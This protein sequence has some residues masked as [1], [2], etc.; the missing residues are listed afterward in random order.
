MSKTHFPIRACCALGAALLVFPAA[1]AAD[2]PA[3]SAPAANSAAA[4]PSPVFDALKGMKFVTNARPAASA[5]YYIILESASWCGPCRREMPLIVKAYPEMKAAGVELVQLSRD[6]DL[7]AAE[8]WAKDEN[9]PF[10]IV[11]PGSEPKFPKALPP[12]PGIPQMYILNAAGDVVA[13]GHPAM[14]LPRWKELCK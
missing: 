6:A 5:K 3:S 4:T 11:A 1:F 13:E 14:L 8:K 10:A 9:A 2:A 12:A 7:K